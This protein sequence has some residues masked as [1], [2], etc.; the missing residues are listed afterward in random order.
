MAEGD[1][2]MRLAPTPPPFQA[3]HLFSFMACSEDNKMP[4]LGS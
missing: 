1:A 4:T 2:S 3:F